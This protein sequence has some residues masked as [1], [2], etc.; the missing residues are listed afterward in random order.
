MT[1]KYFCFQVSVIRHL[2]PKPPAWASMREAPTAVPG[3]KPKSAAASC[4]RPSPSGLPGGHVT[5]PG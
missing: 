1:R 2:I 4:V 5:L 3:S